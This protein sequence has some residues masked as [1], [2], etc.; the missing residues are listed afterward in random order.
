M[1][2]EKRLG[3]I[4]A[5]FPQVQAAFL[6]G[7]RA[8]GRARPESDWDLALYLSPP[9]P[10]PTLEVLEALVEA[11]FERV[12]LLLLHRAPPL[13]AFLAVRG[14]PLFVREGFDL[15]SYVSRVARE[16]WDLEPLLKV[17][18]EALK[19]RWLDPA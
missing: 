10:D 2:E 18:R 17:Q 4:L 1:E 14:K 8:E 3:Q 16:W 9:E 15:G 5:R 11:G 19:R 6:F 7:S 12:D 13:L